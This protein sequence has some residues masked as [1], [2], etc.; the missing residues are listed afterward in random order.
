MTETRSLQLKLESTV[1][2]IDAVELIAKGLARESGYGEDQSDRFA[3]AVR[4]TM[5]N[6][7][8]HGNGFDRRKS[9][10]FRVHV[11]P[12]ALTVVIRD[13]GKGFDPALVPDPTEPENLLKAS[14]RGLLLMR[15]LVDE[16]TLRTGQDGGAEVTLA[17][18]SSKVDESKERGT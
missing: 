6:A 1:D 15:S 5:V 9:V 7:V 2:S 17:I 4:E 13:Q 10:F 12:S 8:E 14:G 16:V 3:M 18:R 11:D